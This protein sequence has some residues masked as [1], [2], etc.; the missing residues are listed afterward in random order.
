[1]CK[2][3]QLGIV[4][5]SHSGGICSLTADMCGQAGLDLPVLSDKA[6]GVI[7]GILKGFGWAANPADVTGKANSDSFPAIMNAMINEPGVGTLAIASAGR[8]QQADQIIALRAQTDKPIRITIPGP[9]TMTQQLFDE[10]Y[11]D[12][13]ALAMDCA[14][15]LNEEI[16]DL[17]AAGADVVQLDEPFLQ[18]Q[19]D[20]A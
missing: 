8:D 2:S 9:F 11:R 3:K 6:R 1:M 15:A 14:A 12:E 17:F 4:V 18:A 10:H 5:V 7:D 16:K 20:K 19:P 13:P